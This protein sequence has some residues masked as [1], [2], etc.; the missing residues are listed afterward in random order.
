VPIS[1]EDNEDWRFV[2]L[3]NRDFAK[4][5]LLPGKEVE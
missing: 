2:G 3:L 1:D 5:Y 4:Q